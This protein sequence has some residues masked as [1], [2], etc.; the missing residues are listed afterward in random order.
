M[1]LILWCAIIAL[2]LMVPQ[3]GHAACQENTT[4]LQLEQAIDIGVEAFGRLDTDTLLTQ[5]SKARMD[6]LPCVSEKLTR[7]QAAAFHRLMAMEAFI[8][9]NDD[10]AIAEFH[11]SLRLDPGYHFPETIVDSGNPLLALY[12]SAASAP[13]GEA[14]PVYPP[15]GGYVMVSGVRNA[16]RYSDTPAIVQVY[17]PGDLL[18]ET[19][20]IQ[21]GEALPKWSDNPMGLTA[22]D[23]GVSRTLVLK[24]PRPWFLATGVATLTAGVFYG[25]AMSQKAQYQDPLTPDT[26]LARY[27]SNA[28]GFGTGAAIAGGAAVVFTGFGIGMHARFGKDGQGKPTVILSP[29]TQS[30][31]V[32]HGR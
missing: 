28:N 27:E 17:G 10:R 26:D 23:L 21:P 20:Y 11:S 14:E 31:E 7:Q 13:D 2:S 19:R 5:A 32:S 16:P 3:M 15:V 30:T 6:I 22:E 29:P 1:K 9:G 8:N 25:I 18:M 12:E 4:T 24:D